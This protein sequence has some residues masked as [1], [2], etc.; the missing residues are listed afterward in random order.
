MPVALSLTGVIEQASSKQVVETC[1]L[2]GGAV[3]V[4]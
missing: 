3:A 2:E 4:T 1:Q